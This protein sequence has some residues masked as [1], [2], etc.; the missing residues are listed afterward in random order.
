MTE[1]KACPA[2]ARG[3]DRHGREDAAAHLGITV[4][5]LKSHRYNTQTFPAPDGH[6]ARSPWW[7]RQ[8]LD[9]WRGDHPAKPR[10]TE[11]DH[12]A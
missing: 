7:H 4:G 3:D 5:T 2:C 1:P 12:A 6:L 9:N 8:T 11:G 10:T